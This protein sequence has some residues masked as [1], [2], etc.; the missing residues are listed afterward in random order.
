MIKQ[1][2]TLFAEAGQEIETKIKNDKQSAKE[3]IK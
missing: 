3:F 2:K 1:K